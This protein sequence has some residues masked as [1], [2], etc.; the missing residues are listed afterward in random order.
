ME[1][2]K[3]DAMQW[4]EMIFQKELVK[5]LLQIRDQLYSLN[6]IS[7]TLMETDDGIGELNETLHQIGLKLKEGIHTY[8]K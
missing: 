7:Q 1:A 6:D 5:V 3:V 8:S 2:D 4:S